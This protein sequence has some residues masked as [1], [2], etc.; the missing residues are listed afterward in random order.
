MNRYHVHLYP[1]VCVLVRDVEADS[2]VEA[3]KKAEELVD[4][5]SLFA[6]QGQVGGVTPE[7]QVHPAGAAAEASGARRNRQVTADPQTSAQT[8]ARSL[9]GAV[10]QALNPPGEPDRLSEE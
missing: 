7:P 8:A 2:Q 5:D 6:G 10:V 1:I 4:L 3:I 9:L